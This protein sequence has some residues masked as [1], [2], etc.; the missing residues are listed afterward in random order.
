MGYTHYWT[1]RR[2]LNADTWKQI[3][4]DVQ[5]ILAYV[6]HEQGIP[7]ANGMG[8]GGTRPEFT[9]DHIAFNGLG[10]DSYETLWIDRKRPPAS[11]SSMRGWAFCKTARKPY[12][13]AVTAVL[14]Y[15]ST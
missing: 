12:D 13:L 15:L 9:A 3:T 4:E 6:E 8:E 5:A 7:L 2:D 14:A 1:Q 11:T 10:D